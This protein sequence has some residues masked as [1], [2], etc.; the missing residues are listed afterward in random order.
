MIEGVAYH[1]CRLPHQLVVL[2]GQPRC[3]TRVH[4]SPIPAAHGRRD[5]VAPLFKKWTDF[6][7]TQL[8]K[9]ITGASTD[10]PY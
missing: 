2:H 7:S 10:A 3:L 4:L 8:S 6:L 5:P 1:A 9:G